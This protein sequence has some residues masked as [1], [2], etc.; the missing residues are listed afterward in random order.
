[1]AHGSVSSS[2]DALAKVRALLPGI[3]SRAAQT[4]EDRRVP[5]V[6]IDELR[7]SG[8]FGVV[9]PK[10][11]GGSELGFADLVRVTVEI[12]TACGSTAW[13]YGV[14]AGHSWLLNMFPE[15]AQREIFADP[16]ALIATVFRLAG[17]VVEEGDGYRLTGGNGRFC[18]GIDYAD[19]VIIGNAVQKPNGF[20][21]P[22]FFVVPKSDI[23]IVDDWF[24]VG[25]AWHRQPFD[26]D[27]GYVHPRPSQLCPQG[28]AGR[29][30]PRHPVA[31]GQ[32][33]TG[34]LSRIW[35]RFR[36]SVLRSAW[37]RER[38]RAMRRIWAA[39]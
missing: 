12:G 33:S 28:H 17:T 8:L 35:R 39:A 16:H 22:R 27:Q 11:L 21:E 30:L 10:S 4:D 13:V 29:Y 38:S 1:M 20:A 36:S 37:P 2:Q 5:D 24:T 15:Q 32:R 19:W 26:P 3:A 25:Y 7:M 23:D 6:S 18:S 34:C 9:M 31:Q 14:L